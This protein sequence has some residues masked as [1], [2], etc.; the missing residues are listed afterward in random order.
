LKLFSDDLGRQGG[1]TRDVA[2]GVR[3]GGDKSCLN[4]IA[5]THHH[6]G[7]G[8][9]RA[10][11]AQSGL[12]DECNNHI[13]FQ[14]NK[15]CGEIRELLVSP[16]RPTVLEPNVPSLDVAKFSQTFV[17]ATNVSRCG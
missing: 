4:G 14:T 15:L 9:R 1:R 5:N 8:P 17:E 12:C 16:F 2:T 10:L 7:D 6:N 3:K 13:D 11:G